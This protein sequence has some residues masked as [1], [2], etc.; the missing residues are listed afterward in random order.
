L[1]S[2]G[3]TSTSTRTRAASTPTSAA[4][5][6]CASM[7]GLFGPRA[8]GSMSRIPYSRRAGGPRFPAMDVL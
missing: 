8:A 6:T 3:V 4:D 2:P 7:R 5:S 1:G